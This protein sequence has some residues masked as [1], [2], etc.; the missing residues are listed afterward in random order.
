MELLYTLLVLL[1]VTRVFGELAE[2]L[3]QPVLVG[4][5]LSGIGLGLL[6]SHFSSS[7]PILSELQESDTFHG[8]TELAMFFLMLLA[9]LD[10]RPTEL[11][12][13]SKS[14]VFIALG[15]MFLPLGLGLGFG[16]LVLPE[17]EARNAQALFLG[18]SLAIT[19]V[20]VSVKVLMDLDRLKSR[21]GQVVVAAALIDDILS[22]LL[23]GV[24]TSVLETGSFP[25]ASGLALLV[26]KLLVFFVVVYALG[27]WLLPR[28]GAKLHRLRS[29]EFAFSFL[30]IAGLAFAVLAE[31]LGM[32]FILGAFAAG[33]FF[34]RSTVDEETYHDVCAKVSAISTGFLAPLFF[35]SMGF[36][37]EVAAF[38]E[39][40][41]FVVTLIVLASA[42]K[43]LGAALPATRAGFSSSE[44][45]A[46]G[47]AMNARGAVELVI[48]GIAL[49]AG[50]FEHPDPAPPIVAH[51]FSTVVIMAIVTTL[52]APIALKRLLRD[53]GDR[54]L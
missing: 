24:L 52:L 35:A 1:A 44:S 26:G 15:G 32:H 27:H 14:A 49:R 41:A 51:M 37:L 43:L 25:G 4:E 5:L 6:V 29:D 40:P 50:L 47:F 46:I 17:S 36:H 33:L 23:L 3:G 7:F 42:G 18:T 53:A 21:V 45:A 19:A 22:L 30:I 11:M 2:R 54:A 48:A 34:R 9:G 8:I 28:V 12:K 39:A 31:A 16:Y 20:P 13:A 38:W 10:L